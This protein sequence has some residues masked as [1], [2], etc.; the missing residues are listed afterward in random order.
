MR[1]F[2]LAMFALA[3]AAPAGCGKKAETGAPSGAGGDRDKLQGT[4]AIEGIDEGG[5]M[6]AADIED[7]AGVRLKFD[8][9]RLTIVVDG[10]VEE[11]FTFATDE[12]ANPKALKLTEVLDADARPRFAS[13]PGTKRAG[14][15][16]P[17]REPEKKEWIYKLDGD[18]LVVAFSNKGDGPRPTEF[19]GRAREGEQPRVTVVTLKKTDAPPPAR[20]RYTTTSR[21]TRK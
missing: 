7:A 10:E 11:R 17:A 3:L 15:P 20:P 12:S 4:W 6:R 9:D 19:K 14:G 13:Y 8:G 18:K 16:P 2:R 21:G 1:L 5:P